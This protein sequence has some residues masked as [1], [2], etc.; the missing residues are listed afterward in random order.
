MMK[1]KAS[2]DND[3]QQNIN[4]GGTIKS[5]EKIDE[6]NKQPNEPAR[7]NIL[8]RTMYK[9]KKISRDYKWNMAPRNPSNVNDQTRKVCKTS[10]DNNKEGNEKY[11]NG[12][13]L[14]YATFPCT[15]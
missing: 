9:I 14:F 13:K 11:K 3:G 2:R 5:N 10:I 7:S 6:E 12:N 1:N 8:M 4:A 15:Q